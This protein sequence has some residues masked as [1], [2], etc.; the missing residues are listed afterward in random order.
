MVL[1]CILFSNSFCGIALAESSTTVQS[2][3]F[4]SRSIPTNYS[5]PFKLTSFNE[6]TGYHTIHSG[7]NLVD[8]S[9][10]AITSYINLQGETAN[11]LLGFV[12]GFDTGISGGWY[13][14]HTI[15]FSIFDFRIYDSINSNYLALSPYS[16]PA[17]AYAR[18]TGTYDFQIYDGSTGYDRWIY[19]NDFYVTK[20]IS[21]SMSNVGSYNSPNAG[22]NYS[23]TV[24][25]ISST[26]L[27]DVTAVRNTINSY[28]SLEKHDTDDYSS[29]ED[30]SYENIRISVSSV[31]VYVLYSIDKT[32]FVPWATDFSSD[33]PTD[34]SGCQLQFF[35]YPDKYSSNL[36]SVNVRSVDYLREDYFSLK[37]IAN[38]F[39][40]LA[41][42]LS[43]SAA[44][45]VT[46]ATNNANRII[47]NTT[48]KVDEVK[49]GVTEVKDS[50]VETKNSILD[51]PNKIKEMLIGL[52]VPPEEDINN[53]FADFETLLSD[54]FGLI[55]QSADIIHDFADSFNTSAVTVVSDRSNA[56]T[57]NFPQVTVSLAG[58]EFVFGGYDVQL[59]PEG[60]EFLQSAVKTA[61]SLVCTILFI[62]MCKNKLEAILK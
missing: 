36:T 10:S 9:S 37:N 28:T 3:D 53:K 4:S 6:D 30:Y 48:Q 7:V 8:G 43:S 2:Y 46:N 50:V 21:V 56:N 57:V 16:V 20:P 26:D 61:I 31:T 11:E 5:I 18:Y 59:I 47:Q 23:L 58:S 32:N 55:Y 17:V 19:D 29:F 38:G 34:L 12:L 14:N 39:S 42:S 13:S 41:S 25:A 60:F 33:I 52:I 27:L 1:C 54:R 35:L 49:Q 45:V 15:D 24:P 22:S 62:N 51:L 44:N 40:S